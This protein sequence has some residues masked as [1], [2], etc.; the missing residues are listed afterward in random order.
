[1]NI[2]KNHLKKLITAI[3]FIAVFAVSALAVVPVYADDAPPPAADDTASV[4]VSTPGEGEAALPSQPGADPVLQTLPEGTAVIAVGEEGNALP[5]ASEPAAQVLEDGD[6]IWCPVGV[7]VPAANTNGCSG[8]YSTFA[9]LLADPIFASGGPAQNGVIWVEKTYSGE[10]SAVNLNGTTLNVMKGFSLTIKG[11]W[12]GLGTGTVD[13]NDPSVFN[14]QLQITNWANNITLSDITVSGNAAGS[15]SL[16]VTTSGSI[17]LTN[18]VVENNTGGG[19]YLDNTSSTS[20]ASVTVTNG[21]F[22]NNTNTND[23]L[24]INSVGAVTLANITANGNGSGTLGSGIAIGNSL[25]ATAQPVTLTNITTNDNRSTGLSVG[26][27]GV[28][29]ATDLTAVHNG[30]GGFGDGVYLSNMVGTGGVTLNGTNLFYQNAEKGLKVETNGAIVASNV[31]AIGNTT[32]GA[33]LDN[34]T[35]LTPQPVT[36]SGSSSFKFNGDGLYV[37]TLGTVTANNITASSNG[38]YGVNITSSYTSATGDVKFTGTNVFLENGD[39]GFWIDTHGAVTMNNVTAN[40]NGLYSTIDNR[41]S[42]LFKGVTLTGTNVFNENN[43]GGLDIKSAGMVTLNNVT[44][45]KNMGSGLVIANNYSGTTNARAVVLNGVNTFN[46]NKNSGLEIYSYGAVTTNNITANLN[47]LS[48][49]NGN[50]TRI[51]NSSAAVPAPVTMNGTNVFNSNFNIGLFVTS[52]GSVKTNNVT[53]NANGENGVYIDNTYLGANGGVTMSGINTINGN[54]GD[55]LYIGSFGAVSLNSVSANGSVTGYGAYIENYNSGTF[56][57]VTISGTNTF[58]LNFVGGLNIS[59]KGVITLNNITANGNGLSGT[60]GSGAYISNQYLSATGG[61]TIT[62]TNSFS[63][64]YSTGLVINSNGNITTNNVT[65]DGNY[66]SGSYGASIDNS[67]GSGN[68]IIGGTNRFVGNNATNLN[69]ISKGTVTLNNI[70]A[71]SSLNGV[72]AYIENKLSGASSPKAVTLTGTNTF[73]SNNQNGLYIWTYGAI[74]TNNVTAIGNSTSSIY[75]GVY[76][77]MNAASIPSP[78]TMKGT[79]VIT[80]SKGSNLVISALGAVTINNLTASN[81]VTGYGANIYNYLTGV[82]GNI[83]FTGTNVFNG[84]FADGLWIDTKGAVS[85]SNVTASSNG[86]NGVYVDNMWSTAAVTTKGVTVLGYLTANNNAG[87]GL[88]VSSYGAVVT[89]KVT[90]NNNAT[91]VWL[92]QATPSSVTPKN[93]TMNGVNIMTGN[94]AEGLHIESLGTVT[95]NAI[96]AT[97]NAGNGMYVDTNYSNATGAVTL[98][99][100]NVFTGNAGTGLTISAN[101]VVTLNNIT[102]NGNGNG[103]YVANGSSASPKAVIIKGFNT[104]SNNTGAYGL[105]IQSYGAITLSNISAGNNA[106]YG[107]HILN[108]NATT[109]ANITLTGVNKFNNNVNDYGLLVESKGKITISNLTAN[110]NGSYGA[111]LDNLGGSSTATV[112]LTGVNSFNGNSD[113]TKAGLVIF[114]NGAVTLSK[115]TADGNAGKGIDITAGAASVTLTCGSFTNNA[116]QGYYIDTTGLTTLIGVVTAGNGMPN[117]VNTVVYKFGCPLP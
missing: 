50:G 48:G 42:P 3:V 46:E 74:T 22:S 58:N 47:G 59:S 17:T 93:V 82:T 109:A 24:K 115:V 61:V 14:G 27:A 98:L 96:T 20:A 8:S 84:N 87:T 38:S 53:A 106:Q 90:A 57:P 40:N 4:P 34:H 15:Y 10:G 89:N 67:T 77:Q 97:G 100:T 5:L 65:A 73:N 19:A 111:T 114:T 95:L 64:N 25:A 104:F 62:G 68:I 102:A 41:F 12:N 105:Y 81:S 31:Q 30:L 76:L 78:V 99:G 94:G 110:G 85:L 83:T 23:G 69:V 2:M 72:G 29:T 79:N 51:N 35:S 103:A 88:Y 39:S 43:N 116:K 56:A 66:A 21:R 86:S 7:A 91:G 28:I 75:S 9:A 60:N 108:N 49:A 44:A 37:F 45:N 70:T 112:T 71:S 26:S 54:G 33:H 101:G 63:G 11:G 117:F 107:A 55:N 113:N 16:Q 13:V 1:M 52:L 36:L 6:P 92:D 80:G 18:V 32:Q